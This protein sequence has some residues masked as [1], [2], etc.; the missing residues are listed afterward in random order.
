M[1]ENAQ[2]HFSMGL[3]PKFNVLV[4]VCAGSPDRST[5]ETFLFEHL[6]NSLHISFMFILILNLKEAVLFILSQLGGNLN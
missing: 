4:C 3:T 2:L 6:K 5:T 1:K